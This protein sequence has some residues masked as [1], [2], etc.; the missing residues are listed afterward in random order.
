M[1]AMATSFRTNSTTASIAAPK[2]CGAFPSRCRRSIW[3]PAIRIVTNTRVAA[4]TMKTTCLVGETSIPKRCQPVG[5]C[6]S[7]NPNGSST[8]RLSDVCSKIALPMSGPCIIAR[9]SSRER[10][11]ATA[12][13]R[14]RAPRQASPPS[15]P[16]A[17]LPLDPLRGRPSR[18]HA[19]VHASQPPRRTYQEPGEGEQRT[20]VRPAVH[21][22]AEPAEY[23]D[24]GGGLKAHGDE[25]K[26]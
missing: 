21:Y 24:E 13:R 19:T 10:A 7:P 2:P 8:T 9:T 5:R 3:R 14:T 16:P 25:E 23:E 15:P 22:L 18:Q 11:A 20:S 1:F 4:T 26:A 12:R 6:H 17:P